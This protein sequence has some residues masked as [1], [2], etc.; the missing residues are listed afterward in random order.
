MPDIHASIEVDR[1]IRTVYDQWTQ[2]ESFPSFMDGV[3]SVRQLDDTHVH[4]RAKV[5]GKEEEWDSEIVQQIPDRRITWRSVG[6]AAVSGSVAFEKLAT[7]RTRVDVTMSYD[8]EGVVENVGSLLGLDSARVRGDLERFKRFI[9]ARV[10]E[11][12][13]WRGEVHGRSDLPTRTP[14]A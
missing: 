13:A 5:G 1:P 12:G 4:W 11:T 10:G 6:G 9:E 2:F 3:V 8:P 7:D 14:E